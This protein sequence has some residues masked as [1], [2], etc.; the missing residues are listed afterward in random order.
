[1]TDQDP[2]IEPLRRLDPAEPDEGDLGRLERLDPEAEDNGSEGPSGG[3]AP[4]PPK[5]G[6]RVRDG[7]TAAVTL[8]ALLSLSSIAAIGGLVAVSMRS[9]A[10]GGIERVAPVDAGAPLT[11]IRIG[12][13]AQGASEEPERD[14]PET[15]DRTDD[16]V[17]EFT[18]VVAPPAPDGAAGGGNGGGN[19]GG[20]GT[21]GKGTGGGPK[22]VGGAWCDTREGSACDATTGGTVLGP[23]TAVEGEGYV[24]GEDD[25]YDDDD[26]DD[27]DDS[28]GGS[29]HGSHPG[30]GH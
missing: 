13:S 18:P 24:G 4:P 9:V 10:P 6:S 3:S 19:S 16:S 20:D 17:V 11:T 7:L 12:E 27:G 5:A 30:K 23:T 28:S 26:D 8:A 21:E 15:P 25:A 2:P 1:M 29:S 22:G 14:R